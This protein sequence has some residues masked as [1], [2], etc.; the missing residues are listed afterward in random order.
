MGILTKIIQERKQNKARKEKEKNMLICNKCGKK[1]QD[2]SS[3][4]GSRRAGSYDCSCG[5]FIKF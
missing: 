1:M 5:Y 3:V 4:R 2:N